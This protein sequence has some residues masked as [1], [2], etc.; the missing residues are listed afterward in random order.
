MYRYGES[1]DRSDAAAQQAPRGALRRSNRPSNAWHRP[2]SITRCD[3]PKYLMA[4]SNAQFNELQHLLPWE[5]SS[6][7]PDGRL[8]GARRKD[9]GAATSGLR[10]DL[11][12]ERLELTG[13]TVLELGSWE[14]NQTVQLSRHCKHVVGIEVRPR[15]V[16]CSL[17]RLWAHEAWN[18]RIVLKNVEDLDESFGTFDILYHCGLLYHLS[19]PVEHLFRMRRIAQT[20]F[21]DTHYGPRDTAMRESNIV[22]GGHT[23]Q[24]YEYE[25]SGWV[26]SL[27]GVDPFSRWLHRDALFQLLQDVG[28][29]DIEVFFDRVE[30]N[31]PRLALVAKA[32]SKSS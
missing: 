28:F 21:L 30:P 6:W 27:S 20:L 19:N 15:N 5:D 31:G 13:K 14:G 2:T 7:L 17:V 16:L 9:L 8:L 26:D 10:V 24:A 29:H 22:Y 23:Y 1:P 25:E 18:A 11:L 32:P 4:L 12:I 3:S